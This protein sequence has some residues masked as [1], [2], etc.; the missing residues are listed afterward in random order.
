MANNQYVFSPT[1][2]L[3]GKWFGRIVRINAGGG[4]DVDVGP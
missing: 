3:V 1:L 4:R 2:S